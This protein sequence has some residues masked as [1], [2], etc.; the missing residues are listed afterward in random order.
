MPPPLPLAACHAG[1]ATVAEL[2]KRGDEFW[3]EFEFYLSDL[4]VGLVLDVV[5]VTLL[6]PPAIIGRRSAAGELVRPHL[7]VLE[8]VH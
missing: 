2:R 1:C 4:L 6:A 7:Y 8:S 3:G 5:L